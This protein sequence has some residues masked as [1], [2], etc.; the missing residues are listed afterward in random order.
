MYTDLRRLLASL[1]YRFVHVTGGAPSGFGTFDAGAGVRTPLAIVGHMCG[2]LDFVREQFEPVVETSAS[3][4]TLTPHNTYEASCVRFRD[5][6]RRLDCCLA[7]G[8]PFDPKR[9]GL[10]IPGL[11][12]GPVSDALTHVG[13][14]ALLR[15]LA[16]SPVEG[17]SYWRVEMPLPGSSKSQVDD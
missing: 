14:L 9:E 10:T 5:K 1:D 3:N 7:E 6:L 2:L 11:L 17:V 4:S 12:Q 16:G 13:Q 8:R 15:R